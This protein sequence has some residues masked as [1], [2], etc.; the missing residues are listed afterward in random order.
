MLLSKK[1][2]V[3][4]LTN[5]SKGQKRNANK[6][7]RTDKTVKSRETEKTNK[8]KEREAKNEEDEEEEE[9]GVVSA[10]AR[11]ATL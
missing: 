5:E 3:I 9:V 11:Q 6:S 1:K 7:R 10:V 4:V 8:Q 2:N